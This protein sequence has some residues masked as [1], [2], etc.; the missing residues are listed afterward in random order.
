MVVQALVQ[1]P[2]KLMHGEILER[3]EPTTAVVPPR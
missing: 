3:A 1:P 2:M